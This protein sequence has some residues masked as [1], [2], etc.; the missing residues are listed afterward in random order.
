MTLLALTS[1]LCTTCAFWAGS[2]HVDAAGRVEFHPYSKGCC[3]GGGGFQY[4]LM[5]ALATCKKWQ[6]WPAAAPDSAPET[7][8]KVEI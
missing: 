2:R 8:N 4:A 7:V 5:A 6:L 1:R 3:R